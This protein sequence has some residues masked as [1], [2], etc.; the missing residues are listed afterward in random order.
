MKRFLGMLLCLAAAFLLFLITRSFLDPAEIPQTVGKE[1]IVEKRC[2]L[3]GI[4]YSASTE[5]GK[6][7]T[8]A[9]ALEDE[10]PAALKQFFSN[11]G[12]GT[13]KE[14]SDWLL[15]RR[16]SQA[17]MYEESVP[18]VL[19]EANVV[20][21]PFSMVP[22]AY[23]VKPRMGGPVMVLIMGKVSGRWKID[24]IIPIKTHDFFLDMDL[25]NWDCTPQFDY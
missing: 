14:K 20:V 19:N 24:N 6:P 10:I 9:P 21:Y 13:S 2:K 3:A 1:T 12:F 15:T 11:G 16:F 18:N 4:D 7:V 8:V 22:D 23:V 17:L 5:K 25:T